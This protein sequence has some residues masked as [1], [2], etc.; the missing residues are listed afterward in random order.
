MASG[1]ASGSFTVDV[2]DSGTGGRLAEVS[3]PVTLLAM[4]A[5]ARDAT[6]G[7]VMKRKGL[8][9]REALCRAAMV[10]AFKDLMTTIEVAE[11]WSPFAG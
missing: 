1:P 11:G 5:Y 10:V 8:T 2:L 7:R 4:E 9:R 6:R 3:I